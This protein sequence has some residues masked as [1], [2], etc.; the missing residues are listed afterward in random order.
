MATEGSRKS[1]R[2]QQTSERTM[3]A[4]ASPTRRT[5]TKKS[6]GKTTTSPAADSTDSMATPVSHGSAATP[7]AEVRFTQGSFPHCA[8]SH[9][10]ALGEKTWLASTALLQAKK[11]SFANCKNG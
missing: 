5:K 6:S 8:L 7:P 3:D 4:T 11:V 1:E 10:S 9:Q 2:G